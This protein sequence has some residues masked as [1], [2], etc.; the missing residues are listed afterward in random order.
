MKANDVSEIKKAASRMRREAIDMT[1][2]ARTTGAHIGGTLSMIEIMAALYLGVMEYKKDE[3]EWE[4]RDRFILSK[5][6][7]VMAQY[8]A[9]K[10]AGLISE[11]E[12]LSFK[13]NDTKLYA[14]PSM[15]SVP[16]IEF[17]SGSLG[18]GL[19]LGVGVA[20]ALK[21]NNNTT[22][23]VFVMLG[24]GECDE[25]T[26]WEA[27]ASASHFGCNELVA[28]IDENMLQYDGKT[29]EIQNK[30]MLAQRFES[31]GWNVVTV[32]GH[33]IEDLIKAF[34]TKCDKPLAIMAR[35]VKGKGIS[36]MENNPL[37]HNGRL[38]EKQYNEAISELTEVE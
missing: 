7:G 20:L 32:D 36:F 27:A 33:T 37:W 26:V 22:S 23:R 24:D 35:T 31:F 11:D 21:R 16:G 17:S 8:L 29:E 3:P 9:M 34:D 6:H 12:L 10:E 30:T 13:T 19:S 2:R 4:E 5:G 1:Y 38:S 14:H 18:Q 28:I 25:G 15:G